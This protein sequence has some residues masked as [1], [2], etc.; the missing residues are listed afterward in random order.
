MNQYLSNTKTYSLNDYVLFNPDSFHTNPVPSNTKASSSDI[1]NEKDVFISWFI[2]FIE[3][4][5]N[6]QVD[7]RSRRH[8]IKIRQK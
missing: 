1:D 8:Y 7:N 3:A 6:M 4:D 2:G 5:G